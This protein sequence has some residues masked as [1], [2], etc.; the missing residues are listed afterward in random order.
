MPLYCIWTQVTTINA[1]HYGL[2]IAICAGHRF[3]VRLSTASTFTVP[4]VFVLIC[5]TQAEASSV[6]NNKGATSSFV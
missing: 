2:I 4:Y 5:G 6:D 3:Q 1:H